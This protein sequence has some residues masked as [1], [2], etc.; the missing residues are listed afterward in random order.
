MK[1][2]LKKISKPI[3]IILILMIILAYA[4]IP[5]ESSSA[6]KP[7]R[8]PSM[9]FTPTRTASN[10]PTIT[11][12]P[13]I[14]PTPTDRPGTH[15]PAENY[16]L[17]LQFLENTVGPLTFSGD[18]KLLAVGYDGGIKIFSTKDYSLKKQIILN[19]QVDVIAFSPNNKMLAAASRYT[20]NSN[21]AAYITNVWETTKW[22]LL[23]AVQDGRG[24]VT[25]I[26][27][28][29]TSH[30]FV[31]G[32]DTVDKNKSAL[33]FWYTNG[34]AISSVESPTIAS[35]AVS[36]DGSKLL[37]GAKDG[38]IYVYDF[39]TCI[40][41]GRIK[42]GNT[43]VIG[44]GRLQPDWIVAAQ[45]NGYLSV[46]KKDSDPMYYDD[47]AVSSG[48]SSSP[49]GTS[50]SF[51]TRYGELITFNY[52]IEDSYYPN[53]G[54]R[55]VSTAYSADGSI[56][57]AS[58]TNNTIRLYSVYSGGKWHPTP[59]PTASATITPTFF[60]IT[61]DILS[62]STSI[63]IR[64]W[65][66]ADL[67]IL[68]TP[69]SIDVALPEI[70]AK[71]R[72][73]FEINGQSGTTWMAFN[74]DGTVKATI[75]NDTLDMV[76]SANKVAYTIS[77]NGSRLNTITFSSTDKW[78]AGGAIDGSIQIWNSESGDLKCDMFTTPVMVK[79]LQFNHKG[80]LL[81]VGYDNLEIDIFDV[82]KCVRV[83]SMQ[84]I[85]RLITDLE[86][87]PND[88]Y[89]AS[90]AADSLVVLYYL[91]TGNR[92][93]QLESNH[94][95]KGVYT[96]AFNPEQTVLAVGSYEGIL[97]LWNPNNEQFLAQY[98]ISNK[99][100]PVVNVLFSDDG[101]NIYACLKDKTCVT[102]GL[103]SASQNTPTTTPTK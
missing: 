85:S 15:V 103:K 19:Y 14:T 5:H 91:Q 20:G 44:L 40:L 10:T 32:R 65:N 94:N 47:L 17:E 97:D 35:L 76:D 49:D 92:L 26:A 28:D 68:S 46:I 29:P 53:Q 31:T 42:V 67:K 90:T 84:K 56:L 58:Y 82:D 59:A 54:N 6:V 75:K 7:T 77:G 100:N 79:A 55:C 64:P 2:N 45:K 80:N 39:V 21:S 1:Y 11:S 34:V 89:L 102:L 74:K 99:N 83:Q 8:T 43:A 50:T 95:V 87:S 60:K 30:V 37:V 33:Y 9:T 71:K 78:I 12:T 93:R 73:S 23:S 25:S 41:E 98:Q 48:L 57:A 3:A 24:L 81:A 66:A 70:L 88:E 16:L 96:L 18:G 27:W 36:I 51:C 72:S 69:V 38:Y 52:T 101:K 4:L 63:A 62:T 22:N 13:T 61:P 86:F